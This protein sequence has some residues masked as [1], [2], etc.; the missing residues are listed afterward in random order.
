MIIATSWIGTVPAWLTFAGV[1]FVALIFRGSSPG[2]AL[3]IEQ[4]AN[5]T[6]TDRVEKLEQ[7]Q[8]IDRDLIAR[9]QA[10]TDVSVALEPLIEWCQTHERLASARADE[11]LERLGRAA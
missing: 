1:V 3:E 9:L 11:I 6:L 2:A 4:R 10:K 7:E 5:K 8:K